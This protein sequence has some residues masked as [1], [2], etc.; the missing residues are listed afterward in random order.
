MNI[1]L[2]GDNERKVNE[3]NKV[4]GRLG[5]HPLLMRTL[6]NYIRRYSKYDFVGRW[7][8]ILCKMVLF[9]K[10]GGFRIILQ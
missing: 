5:Q 8:N 6:V 4:V 1:R 9:S 10:L 7:K 3:R 2:G